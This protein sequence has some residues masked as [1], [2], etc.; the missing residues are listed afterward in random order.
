[1]LALLLAVAAF[2]PARDVATSKAAL[3]QMAAWDTARCL[4]PFE[5]D[6]DSSATPRPD[7]SRWLEPSE[8]IVV[9]RIVELVPGW[10]VDKHRPAT[11]AKLDVIET[12][13]GAARR[14]MTIELDGGRFELG[15][16]TYCLE[17][18]YAMPAAGTTMLVSIR[19]DEAQNDSIFR[20]ERGEVVV[21]DWLLLSGARRVPLA[22]LRKLL[23]PR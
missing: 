14:R 16:R 5:A 13:R 21:P 2:V 22:T 17:P 23:Q 7:L 9:A 10:D 6:P 4:P 15:G 12:L 11:L 18:H 19:H 3:A 1:M 8:V 20:V